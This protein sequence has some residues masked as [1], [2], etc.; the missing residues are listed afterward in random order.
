[1]IATV[2]RHGK[3]NSY[4]LSALEWY[5]MIF[6]HEIGTYESCYFIKLPIQSLFSRDDLHA[7]EL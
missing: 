2:H 7:L 6:S 4:L 3:R 1:M 5:D